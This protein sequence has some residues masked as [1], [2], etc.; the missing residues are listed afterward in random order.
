LELNEKDLFDDWRFG[1]TNNE[2][3][4]YQPLFEE[5]IKTS[6]GLE[7][8]NLQKYFDIAQIQQFPYYAY[9]EK[10]AVSE[11]Q[12]TGRLSLSTSY[13]LFAEII[14]NNVAPW[15]VQNANLTSS[16]ENNSL[17]T[18][19]SIKRKKQF[20]NVRILLSSQRPSDIWKGID[21]ARQWL[22]EDAEDHD[23]YGLLI[24]AVDKNPTIREQV[25]NL[26]TNMMKRESKM[27]EEAFTL[28]PSS[29]EDLLIDADDSYYAAEY[30]RAISLY[31]QV[32]KLDPENERAKNQL[33]KAEIEKP[34]E[35]STDLPREAIQYYR[36]ARSYIAASDVK[37]ATRM[38]GAAIESAHAHG[39]KYLEAEKLLESILV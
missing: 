33:A 16:S 30:E 35:S 2:V 1:S 21:Q 19:P 26:L 39:M 22:N 28:L 8:C 36:R 29:K 13:F 5:L 37:T 11:T 4:G 3:E 15:T 6:Y 14:T 10:I 38:L 18:F 24:D 17:S 7:Q 20:D 23:V 12:G 32:L 25:R 9:G 31:R 27:A 34:N